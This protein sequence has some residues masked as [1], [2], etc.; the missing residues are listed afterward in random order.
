MFKVHFEQK[1]IH[2]NKGLTKYYNPE[3]RESQQAN[4]Y[5]QENHLIKLK[6]KII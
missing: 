3:R 5:K 2:K 4:L 1:S 6:Y